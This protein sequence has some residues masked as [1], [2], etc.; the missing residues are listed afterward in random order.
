MWRVRR[1]FGSV[2]RREVRSGR[3]R[4]ISGSTHIRLGHLT[5]L[6]SEAKQRERGDG[7]QLPLP[8][9]TLFPLVPTLNRRAPRR[10]TTTHYLPGSGRP[11]LIFAVGDGDWD[12]ADHESSICFPTGRRSAPI[13]VPTSA[14]KVLKAI[15]AEVRR[16]EDDE[17]VLY[18]YGATGGGRPNLPHSSD[19][20][21]DPAHR[22]TDRDR[23]V[24]SGLLP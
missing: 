20:A 8:P 21:E 14:S 9:P 2:R 24:A 16:N 18:S 5:T 11:R 13:P 23:I 22:F 12:A 7:F 17:Y 1:D 10:V 3:G 15:H 4:A 19:D 6:L